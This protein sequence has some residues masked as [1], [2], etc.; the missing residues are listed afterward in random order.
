[1]SLTEHLRYS[2]N[3]T[4]DEIRANLRAD[5]EALRLCA[6]SDTAHLPTLAVAIRNLHADLFGYLQETQRDE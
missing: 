4:P 3:R 1:M 6:A 2:V 5:I